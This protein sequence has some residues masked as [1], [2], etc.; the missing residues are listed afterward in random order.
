MI[1]YRLVDIKG[2]VI[3][4]EQNKFQ[5]FEINWSKDFSLANA[6]NLGFYSTFVYSNQAILKDYLLQIHNSAKRS[7][8]IDNKT[9]SNPFLC[10]AD[11]TYA[12]SEEEHFEFKDTAQGNIAT[13]VTG[14]NTQLALFDDDTQVYIA[15]RGTEGFSWPNGIR[16]WVSNAAAE[17]VDF[18]EGKGK[19]HL[20]FYSCFKSV[21]GDIDKFLKE[22]G[23]AKKKIVVTGHSLGGAVATLI[24]AY[25]RGT[26]HGDV[27]L[28]TFGSP[29]VGDA[30]FVK[31]YSQADQVHA[32]R[33]FNVCDV[34]P[35]VPTKRTNILLP[36]LITSASTINPIAFIASSL[37]TYDLSP[38]THFGVPIAL[39]KA[40]NG[41][42]MLINP[43]EPPPFELYSSRAGDNFKT[44]WS[45]LAKHSIAAASAAQHAV[46]QALDV[47]AKELFRILGDAVVGAHQM[48]TYLDIIGSVLRQWAKVY[49]NNE[50]LSHD[51]ANAKHL[52]ERIK[53][54]EETQNQLMLDSMRE[55]GIAHPDATA[56]AATH[57]TMNNKKQAA[58][59]ALNAMLSQKAEMESQLSR[60]KEPKAIARLIAGEQFNA[61]VHREIEFHAE[62][63]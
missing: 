3:T 13:P 57:M 24:A 62:L 22:N 20:G 52:E 42:V 6:L 35:L 36:L 33:L 12:L 2:N 16:D 26:F 28:Y 39:K 32:W 29:R 27:M 1:G 4:I 31:H 50:N 25:I 48:P 23:R 34:V 37:N 9:I 17:A 8:S 56:T 19:V 53:G 18:K 60:L 40:T 5:K 45:E 49:V 21:Q 44:K 43:K 58:H 55:E 38:F 61:H 46:Y 47:E 59:A 54:L 10:P 15:V 11:E 14:T 41:G 63:K 7:F 51:P 30:D